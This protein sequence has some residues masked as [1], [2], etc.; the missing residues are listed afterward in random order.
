MQAQNIQF[1]VTPKVETIPLPD[2]M[3]SHPSG[4]YYT[5]NE[6]SEVGKVIYLG[7][8]EMSVLLLGNKYK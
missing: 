3:A 2:H 8:F 5:Y 1:T 4:Q 7:T 6:I